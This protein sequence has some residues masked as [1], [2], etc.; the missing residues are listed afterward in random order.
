VRPPAF[1]HQP[2][3]LVV[4]GNFPSVPRF[5]SPVSRVSEQGGGLDLVGDRKRGRVRLDLA[6][7]KLLGKIAT[8]QYEIGAWA[9]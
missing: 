5:L 3:Q 8:Y 4:S 2:I 1:L 9:G 7:A 6:C